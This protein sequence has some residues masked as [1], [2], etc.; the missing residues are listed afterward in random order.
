LQ[1]GNFITEVIVKSSSPTPANIP[2][3]WRRPLL[4]SLR[5]TQ[6]ICPL[7]GQGLMVYSGGIRSR[8]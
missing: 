7:S 2:V 4:R 3:A 1:L 5:S 6:S 8:R